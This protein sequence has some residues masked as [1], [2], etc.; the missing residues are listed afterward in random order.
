MAESPDDI[1]GHKTMSDGRHEPLTRAEADRIMAAVEAS[2]ARRAEAMPTAEDAARAMWDAWYRLKELGWQ[3][4]C[5]APAD[6]RLKRTVSVGSSGIHLAYC[7]ARDGS[8]DKW[9]WHPDPDG[10]DLWPHKPMLYL[11]DEEERAADAER[12][13][14][15]REKW[16]NRE[17]AQFSGNTREGTPAPSTTTPQSGGCSECGGTKKHLPGCAKS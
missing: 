9:W 13:A 12:I 14:K 3:D 16:A 7:E 8:D 15:A 6:G 1:V 2:K 17:D 11:P 5:Y 4:P 10:G